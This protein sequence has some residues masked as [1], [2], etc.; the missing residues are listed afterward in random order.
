MMTGGSQDD[1]IPITI[2]VRNARG[3]Q[4][5]S[6]LTGHFVLNGEQF[7]FSA[8]AFGRVGGQNISLNISKKTLMRVKSFGLDP[9]LLQLT[10]QR[11]LI[12]GDVVI[13]TNHKM[14]E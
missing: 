2:F 1:S 14:T 7:R 11:K 9:D 13:L 5:A 3:G 12:E 4:F 10:I 8:I 6:K